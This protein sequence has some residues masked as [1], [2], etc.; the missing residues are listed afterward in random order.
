[1]PSWVYLKE[2]KEAVTLLEKARSLAPDNASIRVGLGYCYAKRNKLDMAIAEIRKAS[3]LKPDDQDI[4]FFLGKLFVVNNDKDA[5]IA[6]QR[7]IS[8]F[9]PELARKLYLLI[10]SDKLLIVGPEG[11][12]PK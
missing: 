4:Q 5:A 12:G 6:Q 3:D 1:M 11:V 9:N 8:A 7:K 10:N 2:F